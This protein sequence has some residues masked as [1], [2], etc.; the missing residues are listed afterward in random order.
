MKHKKTA[1]MLMIINLVEELGESASVSLTKVEVQRVHDDLVLMRS[2][3]SGSDFLVDSE[4]PVHQLAGSH[5][6]QCM[7]I[8]I[9]IDIRDLLD[10][11]NRVLADEN[12]SLIKGKRSLRTTRLACRHETSNTQNGPVQTA[13]NEDGG[14]NRPFRQILSRCLR[15]RPHWHKDPSL[16]GHPSDACLHFAPFREDCPKSTNI[17]IQL[18]NSEPSRKIV[19]ASP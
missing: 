13:S 4:A 12:A 2:L 19:N 5:P 8:I 11:D 1:N 16:L 6:S 10:E 3:G 17:E 18:I 15:L 7:E 14:K 9:D